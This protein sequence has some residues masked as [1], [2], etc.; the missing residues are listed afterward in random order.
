MAP[1]LM[2]I[3]RGSEF[4][5][6]TEQLNGSELWHN[7]CNIYIHLYYLKYSVNLTLSELE[8]GI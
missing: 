6:I 8:K 2:F 3:K 5:Y 1:F 7:P 4:V